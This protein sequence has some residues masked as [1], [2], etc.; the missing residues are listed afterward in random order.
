MPCH[1]LATFYILSSLLSRG[2]FFFFFFFFEARLSSLYLDWSSHAIPDLLPAMDLQ[3]SNRPLN[4]HNLREGANGNSRMMER[5]AIDQ[6]PKMSTRAGPVMEWWIAEQFECSGFQEEEDTPPSE[7]EVDPWEFTVI[8]EDY[9]REEQLERRAD[10]EESVKG[11]PDLVSPLTPD[12][13]SAGFYGRAREAYESESMQRHVMAYGDSGASGHTVPQVVLSE[14]ADNGNKSMPNS[15]SGKRSRSV[16]ISSQRSFKSCTEQ[17]V[18]L[19]LQGSLMTS[20][21][22]PASPEFSS[23]SHPSVSESSMTKSV[24][25][26]EFEDG[27]IPVSAANGGF[28][29]GAEEDN[30]LA[31][32]NFKRPRFWTRLT[33]SKDDGLG[34]PKGK[35]VKP[36]YY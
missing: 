5:R 33:G 24:S 18:A 11:D 17:L 9:G 8:I 31:L 19:S 30:D 15:W 22:S 12:E 25:P 16:S 34:K 2:F 21:L 29:E 28:C 27:L 1:I 23:R 26:R 4:S 36:S 14:P 20:R 6:P 7:P 10:A 3:H 35:R 32:G 13:E